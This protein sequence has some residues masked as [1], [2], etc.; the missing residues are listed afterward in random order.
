RVVV[1][2]RERLECVLARRRRLHRG[3]RG[4]QLAR[5]VVQRG[6]LVVD[7]EHPYAARTPARNFG[8]SIRTA[9][10]SPGRDYTSSPYAG[11]NVDCSRACTFASPMPLLRPS[12]AATASSAL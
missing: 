10:P 6:P 3:A 9:V 8:T 5:E 12:N 7:G 4:A 2:G 1:R 11:P